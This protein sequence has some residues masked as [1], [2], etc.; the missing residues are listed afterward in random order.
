[1]VFR[2]QPHGTMPM[3]QK[4][5]EFI[6]SFNRSDNEARDRQAFQGYCDTWA[7][8]YG[9]VRDSANF[10]TGENLSADLPKWTNLVM[11]RNMLCGTEMISDGSFGIK[12]GV[13]VLKVETINPDNPPVGMTHLT[14]PHLIH[15]CNIIRPNIIDGLRQV[16]PFP[17]MGGRALP[18]FMPSLYPLMSLGSVYIE[19]WMLIKLPP[20]STLPNQYHP[21]FGGF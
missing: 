17:Q 13:P 21:F 19:M 12:H 1:M 10:I 16:D 11:G 4:I 18:P 14:H 2:L 7:C 9:K 20:G 5:Q 8:N 3:T 6:F 15:H